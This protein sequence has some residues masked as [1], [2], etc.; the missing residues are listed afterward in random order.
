M[1]IIKSGAIIQEGDW[2]RYR[3]ADHCTQFGGKVPGKELIGKV[4][5][6]FESMDKTYKCL[7]IEGQTELILE[8]QVLEKVPEEN[9]QLNRMCRSCRRRNVDCNGTTNPVWTGCVYRKSGNYMEIKIVRSQSANYTPADLMMSWSRENGGQFYVT[10]FGSARVRYHGQEWQYD[11]WQ[12]QKT[13]DGTEEITL[14][15]E[16][17]KQIVT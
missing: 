5:E 14:Y 17:T 1:E 11:H 8:K 6:I 10:R 7:W 2:V 16:V 3:T 4:T 12:I 13:D 9:I 15:L